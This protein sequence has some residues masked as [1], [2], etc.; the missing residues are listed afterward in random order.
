MKRSIAGITLALAIQF[1]MHAQNIPY[2]QIPDYPD[3]YSNGNV[4]GRLVDGLGYRFYWATEG[5]K[6]EDLSY[7]PSDDGRTTLETVVH[8]FNMSHTLLNTTLS[9]PN[10]GRPDS[11]ISFMD[12]RRITLE[13]FQKASSNL[14]S[15]T[16]SDMADYKIIFAR[17]ENTSEFPFWNMINGPIS[18]CIY[19]TGQVVSFRRSS[20][21]PMDQNVNVFI[22]KT[23]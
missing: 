4:A 13:N 9:A 17:G 21:N 10:S 1:S 15:G 7:K 14:K 11:E 8:I 2:Q 6:A 5:L 16:E 20:G 12:L 23:R 3:S 18:D 19:H 22:G